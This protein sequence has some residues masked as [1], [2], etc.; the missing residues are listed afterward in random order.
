MVLSKIHQQ[1]N[2][3]P[4]INRKKVDQVHFYKYLGT[5]L[6]MRRLKVQKR[7]K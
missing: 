1:E 7:L 3:N 5:K 4:T 6:L 2:L